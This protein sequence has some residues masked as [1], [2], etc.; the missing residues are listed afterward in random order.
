MIISLRRFWLM[1]IGVVVA[2]LYLAVIAQAATLEI[3]WS[4]PPDVPNVR[5]EYG[6]CS[7]DEFDEVLG[8]LNVK[9]PQNS[10]NLS[11]IPFER[12]CLR[13][14]GFD[15]NGVEVY[16]SPTSIADTMTVEVRIG[17]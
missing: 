12:T 11:Y 15:E 8:G 9:L 16:R 3:A 4:N 13:I 17:Q 6:T 2:N 5:L 1:L 7:G 10:A 14:L